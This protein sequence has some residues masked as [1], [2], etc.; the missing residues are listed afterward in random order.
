MT[1]TD[2]DTHAE[3]RTDEDWYTA[4]DTFGRAAEGR[5]AGPE[6]YAAVQRFYARQMQMLDEGPVA[7]WAAT[8]TEDGVF[9]ATGRAP[10]AG[11]AAIEA[12][13]GLV[14]AGLDAA[15]IRRRHWL[16]ML[17]VD[18]C[19]RAR[20]ADLSARCYAAVLETARGGA[21]VVA[22]STTCEDLLVRA[23]EG[24]LVRRRVVRRDDLP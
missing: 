7:A 13:A 12:A 18:E 24:F 20:D 17:V 21:T 16:G 10:V 22:S 11:R 8:F 6:N 23:G 4:A 19:T 3:T 5:P 2:T 1:D 14:R 15:G 9:E